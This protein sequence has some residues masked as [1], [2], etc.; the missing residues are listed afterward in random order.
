MVS[1]TTSSTDFYQ[2]YEDLQHQRPP[3]WLTQ[4]R[5][6]GIEGFAATGF[7]TRKHEEY[8]YTNVKP[9]RSGN[10]TCRGAWWSLFL[11]FGG[12]TVV[13]WQAVYGFPWWVFVFALFSAASLMLAL[14]TTLVEQL[15][16]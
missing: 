4:M 12:L 3:Q 6:A 16:P 1:P 15:V 7:P 2:V 14:A 5:R 8:K 13:S 10:S 9:C 11:S